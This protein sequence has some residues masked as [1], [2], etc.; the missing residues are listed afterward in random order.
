MIKY[1]VILLL[2]IFSFS[3][4]SPALANVCRHYDG[5]EICILSIKRSAKKY[6][7]YRAA[8]SVDGVKT[9]VEIYNCRGK[10]KI[11]KNRTLSQ[12]RD[13]SPGEMICSFF[14]K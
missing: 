8:I 5:H 10:F 2:L 7:E 1:P 11:N 9:P 6:W 12:F 13:K 14:K 3:Y 4:T